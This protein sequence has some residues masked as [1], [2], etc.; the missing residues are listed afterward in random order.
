MQL[1]GLGNLLLLCCHRGPGWPDSANLW[2]VQGPLSLGNSTVT[3][4]LLGCKF[5]P[6]N[7]IVVRVNLMSL[8]VVTCTPSEYR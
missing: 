5:V 8:V 1:L 3:E 7:Y 4:R 6:V 2:T